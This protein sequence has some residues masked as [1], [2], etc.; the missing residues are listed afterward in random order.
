M[1]W[2]GLTPSCFASGMEPTRSSSAN[3]TAQELIQRQGH[4]SLISGT[5]P[6]GAAYNSAP[7]ARPG[8]KRSGSP[9]VHLVSLH[10]TRPSRRTEKR[11][12]AGWSHSASA[13]MEITWRPWPGKPDGLRVWNVE[14]GQIV[15]SAGLAHPRTD[16]R[17]RRAGYWSRVHHERVQHYEIVILRS[18][19]R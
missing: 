10:G 16:L 13:K 9:S 19:P 14:T 5:S 2:V 15:V 1:F 18:G 17:R 3:Y 4:P 11:C 7:A 6:T 8:P 12:R